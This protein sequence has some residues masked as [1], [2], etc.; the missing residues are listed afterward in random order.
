MGGAGGGTNG[1]TTGCVAFPDLQD[2][3]L[4]LSGAE[5]V[6][7]FLS[8]VVMKVLAEFTGHLLRI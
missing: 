4:G 1:L 8:L 2:L 6:S 3:R 5:G 7:D